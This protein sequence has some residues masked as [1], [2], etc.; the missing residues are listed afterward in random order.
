MA[1]SNKALN[2]ALREKYLELISKTMT[3]VGEE[4]LRVGSN[5]I[6]FPCVDSVGN[7]KYIILT[8]KVPIGSRDGEAYDGY[9]MAEDYVIKCKNKAEAAEKKEKE[10]AKKIARDEK[11]RAK[12][13]TK[14]EG[15]A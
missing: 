15:E 1:V 12:E 9:S 11:R 13:K 5:E 3:E 4:V 14:N 10:K 7:D 6:C 8:V 2:D